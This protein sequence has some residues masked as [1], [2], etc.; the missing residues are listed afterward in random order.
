M[1]NCPYCHAVFRSRRGLRQHINTKPDCLAMERKKLGI[2]KKPPPAAVKQPPAAAKRTAMVAF[3]SDSDELPFNTPN[4]K[5]VDKGRISE[6]MSPEEKAVAAAFQRLVEE[7]HLAREQILG[8]LDKTTQSNLSDIDHYRKMPAQE[9]KVE[10]DDDG[11]LLDDSDSFEPFNTRDY[12][13]RYFNNNLNVRQQHLHVAQQN[14]QDPAALNPGVHVAEPDY[15]H[16]RNISLHPSSKMRDDF[17]QYCQEAGRKFNP[18]LNSVELRSIKLLNVLKKKRA[19]LDSYDELMDWHHREVGDIKQHET[20]KDVDGYLSRKAILDFLKQRYFMTNK[21]PTITELKLPSSMAKVKITC[22]N[23]WD[24]IQSLLT[25][26]RVH[27]DDYNFPDNNPLSPPPKGQVIGDFHTAR[28]HKKAYEKYITD[29]TSQILLPVFFYIDGAVTGQFS[30]LPITALKMALGIHT[31]KYRDKPQAWRTLGYVAQITKEQSRGKSLFYESGHI[32]ADDDLLDGEGQPSSTTT[33][34]KS[35]DFHIMLDAILESYIEV[36]ENGF[37]WDLRYHGQ[38]YKNIE[39]IPYVCFVKCDTDEA[40]LLCGSY[41][42]RAE[43]VAQLCQYCHCPTQESDLVRAKYP[44]KT[45][46]EIQQLVDN[47]DLDSLKS[48]SQQ[49]IQNAWYKIRFSPESDRGIHGACPSEMLHALLLG[50]FK[51]TRDCFFE[52]TGKSSQLSDDLNALAQKY[53]GEFGRQSERD[54]PKC[55]FKEG[56]RK[57]KLNAK[58]FR[59]IL[60]VMAA[61]IRSDK[62]RELL[63]TNENFSEDFLVKDWMILVEMLLEWEAYLNQE[64]MEFR[65]VIR[66]QRK[67]RYIMYVMKKVARRKEGMGLKLMKF[68]AI[69]HMAWDIILFGIPLEVDTGS[70]ESG[71]KETKVAARLTQKNVSTFDYQTCTRLDEMFVVDMAMEEINGRKLWEYY[72]KEADEP[73]ESL[74]VQQERV[75]TGGSQINIFTDPDKGHVPCFSMGTGKQSRVPSKIHWNKD[76]VRFLFGLQ[77]KLQSHGLTKKLMIRTEHKR[78][79]VI[80]RGSPCYRGNPWRDWVMVDW[81]DETLPGQIWCFIVI[82][83]MRDRDSKGSDSTMDTSDSDQEHSDPVIQHGGIDLENGVYAI[84]E[85]ATYVTNQSAMKESDLFIPIT[86]EVGQIANDNRGWKRKFYL[87]DVEAFH[88]PCVVVP[89]IG[90]KSK[91]EYFVVRP[92]KHWAEE[93]IAWL[94]DDPKNDV[95]GDEEPVPSGGRIDNTNT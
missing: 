32:D 72:K 15:N 5:R 16:D 3:D 39:F 13:D 66:M 70:N 1:P 55:K 25:D 19:S 31:R 23:P 65:D 24:C 37:F 63:G 26:P 93:F 21:F 34:P 54:M 71:H 45:V 22:H 47:K 91:R 85:N 6:Q 74:C 82:T 44:L 49:N 86:K 79:G 38:T 43:G 42:S 76:I 80:F 18:N 9:E 7:D 53:G 88:E 78:N 67:N 89:N 58:E 11:F 12:W 68:H 36:Q 61:L 62:G 51:Y 8:N 50:I 30:N 77:S 94:H 73:R 48:I 52:Q 4:N 64:E 75:S 2:L 17:Q 10:V 56:I 29:P 40:D 87:A 95:F 27:D 90:C 20:V 84:L 69:V 46:P 33:V 59:G 60:L 81:G 28:A 14:L 92:R 83:C 35:Q 41:K 57:G